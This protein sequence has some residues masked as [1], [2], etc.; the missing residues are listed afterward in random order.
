MFE[1]IRLK[2]KIVKAK[3]HYPTN[4]LVKLE[5]YPRPSNFQFSIFNSLNT[6]LLRL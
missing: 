2:R 4:P 5:K 6:V 1:A 3:Y